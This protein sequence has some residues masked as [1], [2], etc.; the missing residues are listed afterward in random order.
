MTPKDALIKIMTSYVNKYTK[1]KI[2]EQNGTCDENER[3]MLERLMRPKPAPIFITFWKR[4]EKW[5][6]TLTPAEIEDIIMQPHYA[7][8]NIYFRKYKKYVSS[9]DTVLTQC[10]TSYATQSI[11]QPCD[12]KDFIV[13]MLITRVYLGLGGTDK[14]GFESTNY[15]GNIMDLFY[16]DET[17]YTADM[18]A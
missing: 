6:N 16:G 1:L 12:Y 11:L 13:W 3:R 4:F 9:P 17:Y 18:R 14:D 8:F 2:Y 7:T 10:A 15:I 5:A